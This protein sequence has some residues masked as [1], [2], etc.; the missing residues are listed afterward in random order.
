M[1]GAPAALPSLHVRRAI[2]R[3]A[4]CCRLQASPLTSSP[5]SRASWARAT[6]QRLLPSTHGAA[7]VSFQGVGVGA[8]CRPADNPGRGPA[9]D[10][11]PAACPHSAPTC[12]ADGSAAAAA[13]RLRDP[14]PGRLPGGRVSAACA[15]ACTC[16][17]AC[18]T[19]RRPALR[20]SVLRCCHPSRPRHNNARAMRT[21]FPSRCSY[22]G[23][24]W[25]ILLGSSISMAGLAGLAAS[26]G[27]HAPC[28]LWRRCGRRLCVAACSVSIAPA[29]DK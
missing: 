1:P 3:H 25:V 17:A 15:L 2:E 27:A 29:A 9:P 13:C 5:T 6:A 16:A 8:R 11:P 7:P 28:M 12:P 18:A 4:G 26:A 10:R 23:R 22:L 14:A 21:R 19:A 24:F 20:W